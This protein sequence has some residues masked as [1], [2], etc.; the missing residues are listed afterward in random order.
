MLL[1][2]YDEAKAMQE[3]V[4]RVHAH[5]NLN[6][7]KSTTGQKAWLTQMKNYYLRLIAADA[8]AAAEVMATDEY[9]RHLEARMASKQKSKAAQNKRA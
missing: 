8:E 3:T 6:R 9:I 1:P 4:E 2:E 5:W 7:A